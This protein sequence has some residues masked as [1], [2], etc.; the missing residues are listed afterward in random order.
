MGG[1]M[2]KIIILFLAVAG[3]AAFLPFVQMSH[4]Q[5]ISAFPCLVSISPC[6]SA[7]S[8]QGNT[9][10]GL[11][12]ASVAGYFSPG[13]AG[14]GDY[15]D[16]G[17]ALS[18]CASYSGGGSISPG[19]IVLSALTAGTGTAGMRVGEAVTGTG[20]PQGAE[21]A[22]I[23]SGS[24]V[25]MTL[26][27]T[28]N[29]S[30]TVSISGDNSGTLIVDMEPS[31]LLKPGPQC[32]QKTNYRGDPHEWGAYGDG[33][34]MYGHD[35]TVALQNWLG[36][37][38]SAVNTNSNTPATNFGPWI[39]TIPANYSVSSPLVCPPYAV[40]PGIANISGGVPNNGGGAANPT[41]IITAAAPVSGIPSLANAL[42]LPALMTASQYCR[43][44]G[45]TLDVNG[46]DAFAINGAIGSTNGTTTV[47]FMNPLAAWV[48]PGVP[49][50]DSNA[51][52]CIPPGAVVMSVGGGRTTVTISDPQS[53]P[54][55]TCATDAIT[56]TGFYN[57]DVIGTHVS[58]DGHT[59]LRGGYHGVHCADYQVDGLEIRESTVFRTYDN[60]VHLTSNC[61]DVRVIGDNIEK[62]GQ[63][64]LG[65]GLYFSGSDL[66]LESG[67][68][69]ESAGPDILISGARLV[70]V[71]GMVVDGSGLNGTGTGIQFGS[72]IVVDTST[73]VSICGNRFERSGVDLSGSS[74]VLFSGVSDNIT[75]CGN[76]YNVG[77]YGNDANVYPWYDFDVIGTPTLTNLHIY[78]TAEQPVVSVFNP[79]LA[80]LLLQ[81]LQIPQFTNNQLSGL[82]LSN[83]GTQAINIAPG[84]ATDSTNSTVISLPTGCS[85]NLA[86][87]TNGAN[88][89]DTGS[90]ATSTTYYIFIIAAPAAAGGGS[91]ATPSCMAST[92]LV[93]QFTASSFVSASGYV[94]NARGGLQGSAAH[95]NNTVLYVNPLAGVAAGNAIATSDGYIPVGTTITGF[96]ANQQPL[97]TITGTWSSSPTTTITVNGTGTGYNVYAG[98]GI[99]DPGGCIPNGTHIA[100]AS[101]T[102]VTLSHPT[103]CTEATAVNL[104]ISGAQQLT[105]SANTIHKT[106]ESDIQISI[107]YYRMI[108]AIYTTSAGTIVPFTQSGD[109]F[110]LVT[111]VNDIN[112]AVTTSL[113]LYPLSVPNGIAVEALGRCIGTSS[114]TGG[115]DILI[116]TP[117][118]SPGTPADFA[119]V[120]G[121][122][123]KTIVTGGT[124][125]L[126]SY[127][128]R[129]YTDTGTNIRA[130][131]NA[132]STLQCMTDGWVYHRAQ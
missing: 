77:S 54:I 40:L 109:T 88:A 39:A 120:P 86:S 7:T 49:I 29:G 13:D 48:V 12:V 85:V 63:D 110:N 103:T 19:S 32:W 17:A 5:N 4:A 104:S 34:G 100:T 20:I 131:A 123:I 122:A 80:Q 83:S 56:I 75:L 22:S 72:G 47:S 71:N 111:P 102:T 60:G 68:V 76:T 89:L 70:T 15:V 78:D 119:A 41:V 26:A 125:P 53:A 67:I 16:L 99:Q 97:T 21:V 98:M 65:A 37:Y 6:T 42:G 127:P 121:Y 27:A 101:G 38:G 69:Q 43:I 90:I 92:S 105:L 9:T 93:P 28:G 81:P 14:G 33:G 130:R 23:V 58:I 45:I 112:A 91:V 87:S 129:L 8:L 118:T 61:D 106:L 117:P 124:Q 55:G 115:N 66:S 25:T 59:L 50:N 10:T 35:D 108:G 107:G 128:Y 96:T 64:T 79:A 2:K 116:Y 113:A 52:N 46:N 24:K 132:A 31:G 1:R 30:V 95:P 114:L 51:G 36:A 57:V 82:V 74:H 94:V 73:H 18:M 126:V 3:F 11:V 84:E 44:S 62:S